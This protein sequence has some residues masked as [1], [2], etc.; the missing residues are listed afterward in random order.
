MK[1]LVSTLCTLVLVVIN[2]S[3][4]HADTTALS[5]VPSLSTF[6]EG[7]RITLT[8][9]ID[10]PSTAINAVSGSL[11]YPD[12]L[13]RVVSVTKNKSIFNL[14]TKEPVQSRNKISFEGVV[15]NPG[16]QGTKGIL[17]QV[18]FEARKTGT[19][20]IDF[21]DGAVLANDGLGTNL[22]A[23]LRSTKVTIVKPALLPPD[24][25]V[26]NQIPIAS[27]SNRNLIALPVITDFS[28][29][30]GQADPMYVKGKGQPNA[31]TKIRF[32]D[33]SVKSLG[34]Q[35]VL[36]VQ[37]KRIALNEVIVQNSSEGVFEYFSPNNIIAG[38][39][40]ATPYLVDETDQI[41][42]PGFGVQIFVS[43][44]PIVRRLVVVINILILLIPIVGLGV[45]IYFIPWYSRLRMR[46]I[47]RRL[48]LEEQKIHLS[49]TEIIQKEKQ[50][51]N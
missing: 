5:L 10:S 21:L 47:Q 7:D 2:F 13:L 1:S 45:L 8:V 28:S 51:G 44:S 12:S 34:E 31:L 46:L 32:R 20:T 38:T 18:V 4:V 42:K 24:V 25:G 15:V 26:P 49:E 17:F 33:T 16:F 39:Y 11:Q 19:A 14:W 9:Q 40:N 22:L 30:V 6:S 50:M 41:E 35:F 43:E 29:S 27:S 3:V 36:A 48:R 23:T 37:R